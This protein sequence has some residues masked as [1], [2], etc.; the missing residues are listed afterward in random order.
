[1]QDSQPK[2]T[3]RGFFF[4]F[5]IT[6]PLSLPQRYISN[7]LRLAKSRI[8]L[9]VKRAPGNGGKGYVMESVCYVQNDICLLSLFASITMA[10]LVMAPFAA[11]RLLVL[12]M[13]KDAIGKFQPA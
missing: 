4:G 6:T 11:T 5:C 9:G 8:M 10:F 2:P 7:P 13:R 3:R 1:M 12:R